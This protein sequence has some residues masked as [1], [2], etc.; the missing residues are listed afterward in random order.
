MRNTHL[1]ITA[2]VADAKR[3]DEKKRGTRSTLSGFGCGALGRP[4][5][6]ILFRFSQLQLLRRILPVSNLPCCFTSS[7][8]FILVVSALPGK[9]R[10]FAIGCELAI[11]SG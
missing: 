9:R 1:V 11:F 8:S 5:W 2:C 7:F 3:S 6:P 10:M 4:L